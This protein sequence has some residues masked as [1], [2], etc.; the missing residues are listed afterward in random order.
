MDN[1]SITI[2]MITTI[3]GSEVFSTIISHILYNKKLNKELKSK[4]VSMI[5]DEI[6][7]G[8]M[9]FRDIELYTL[10]QEF[11]NI[12]YE[13]ELHSDD[14]NMFEPKPIYPEFFNNWK[15]YNLFWEKI[16]K[17][18][19][20]HEKLFSCKIALYLVYIDRYLT[21]L[22]IYMS[23]FTEINGLE[24]KD[25]L[26]VFGTIFIFDIQ[27]WQRKLDVLLVKELNKCTNKLESHETKKWR[28]I[29]KK[30]LEKQWEDS[31]F[32]AVKEEDYH[33]HNREKINMITETIYNE[34]DNILKRNSK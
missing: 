3:V 14:I 29:R 5:A 17:C 6:Q 26:P 18:R 11:Y 19:K 10:T 20:E 23:K 12:E 16:R 22:S 2:T 33:K 7:K 15:S 8:L 9:T 34:F 27:D 31:L 1:S 32:Y 28:K 13:L 4:G 30:V 25:V 24:D 21:Q